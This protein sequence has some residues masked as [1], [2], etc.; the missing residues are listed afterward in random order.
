MCYFKFITVL[1]LIATAVKADD[2]YCDPTLCPQG[3]QP[4]V[5]CDVD[6]VC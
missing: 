3:V 6:L 5:A 1:F 2:S 4:H